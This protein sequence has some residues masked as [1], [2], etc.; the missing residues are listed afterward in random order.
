MKDEELGKPKLSNSYNRR[1]KKCKVAPIHK[2]NAIGIC[3]DCYVRL[4]C[5]GKLTEF[6]EG[7]QNE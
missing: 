6:L 2:S 5:A 7:E 1:C 4:D 3:T